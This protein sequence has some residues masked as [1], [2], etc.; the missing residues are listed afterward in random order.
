MAHREVLSR[1]LFE[2]GGR[3]GISG[4]DSGMDSIARELL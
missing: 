1:K 4:S 2:L 3:T